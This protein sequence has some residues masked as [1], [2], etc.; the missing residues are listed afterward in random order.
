MKDFRGKN[1]VITGAASG[2]GYAIAEALARE[3]ARV[4]LADVEQVAL[5]AAVSALRSTGA[6]VVGVRTDVTSFD[7]MQALEKAAVAA[8][9]NVHVFVGNAGVGAHEDVSMW[10]LPLNDW[11]W[12]MAV[13]VWGIIHGIKAF[14]PGMLA[15]GEEGHVVHTSSGNGG[16]ILVP[17]TPIYSATKA[18][19]SAISES[20]H[21]QLAMQGAKIRAH[22]LYPGPHIVASNIFTAARNRPEEF[23]REVEQVAP[24]VTLETLGQIFDAMGRKFETT[25]PAE[26]AEHTLT[27]IKE[28]R[29]YILPWTEDGRKRFRERVDGILE[30]R[31]PEPR[32]F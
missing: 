16:L 7:S 9:G 5:D 26:V 17:T 28:D 8:H 3:G 23:R 21:L 12:C 30:A 2:I 18:A 11:R 19:V 32:F 14:V 27:G 24:P 20:L 13:N 25:S 29:F 4:V 6:E 31:D 1:A 15:H 22:V 10:D